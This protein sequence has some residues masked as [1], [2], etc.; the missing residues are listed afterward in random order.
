[1]AGREPVVEG[2][3]LWVKRLQR[4]VFFDDVCKLVEE[5][6]DAC[7]IALSI[8]SR[9]RS[10]SWSAVFIVTFGSLQRSGGPRR[11]VEGGKEAAPL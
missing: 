6:V 9:S 8:R 1:L 2:D 3:R 5:R 11:W 10:S 7:G 4:R